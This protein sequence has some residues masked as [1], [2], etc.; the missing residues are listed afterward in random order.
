ML[1]YSLFI[2]RMLQEVK[3]AHDPNRYGEI[4]VISDTNSVTIKDSE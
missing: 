3:I 1:M 2:E 4:S